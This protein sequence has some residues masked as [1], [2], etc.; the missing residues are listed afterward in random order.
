MKNITSP[1]NSF[2]LID[3][4]GDPQIIQ[5]FHESTE[6]I[7]YFGNIFLQISIE[8]LKPVN[9]SE[10]MLAY[11]LGVDKDDAK[12]T[13]LLDRKTKN[14]RFEAHP[15][16]EEILT[17]TYGEI[18]YEEQIIAL[19]H[20]LTGFSVDEVYQLYEKKWTDR[21][22]AEIKQATLQNQEFLF[23]CESLDNLQED[24]TDI[25]KK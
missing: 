13:D 10:L 4:C 2:N 25:L 20:R 12:W 11:C 18:I 23:L 15:F 22:M 8:C 9:F 24:L 6:N 14:I 21:V 17:S 5:E 16:V 1:F 3:F 7:P 19:L